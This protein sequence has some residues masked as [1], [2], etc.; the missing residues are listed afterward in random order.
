[1]KNNLK[2][3]EYLLEAGIDE[4]LSPEPID[5][6]AAVP[7]EEKTNQNPAVNN[8]NLASQN[9]ASKNPEPNSLSPK[10]LSPFEAIYHLAQKQNSMVSDS[11]GSLISIDEK[12][13][14]A[15][16]MADEAN[17]LVSLKQAVMDFDGCAL[18]KM[19]TNTV[20]A[21]GD[22][23]SP[24][25]IIGEA[26]GNDEDLQGIPFCGQSGKLLNEMFKNIGLPR[27]KLYITNTLFWRPPGN[28]RPTDDELA[29]C[30][31][32]VEKHIFLMKPK[33]I[34]LMG[35]TAMNNI[36][37]LNNPIS[38]MRGKFFEYSNSLIEKNSAPAITTAILFHPSYLLRQSFK[39]KEAWLD[40]LMIREFIDTQI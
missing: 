10:N 36:L 31:P 26:P 15:Q 32:F 33:L 34:I 37:A 29:V 24:I 40:L 23:E 3:A 28:R 39:K 17:D 19:A 38:K 30:R 7:K 20:F 18:K 27:E 25:M 5:R 2:L 4:I 1:M 16:K 14:Q 22:I 21:D 13:A 35:A 11:S 8:E 12:I 9:L 6:L